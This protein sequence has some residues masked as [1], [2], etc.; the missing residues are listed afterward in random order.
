[1]MFSTVLDNCDPA[2]SNICKNGRGNFLDK[3]F[4]ISSEPFAHLH[5]EEDDRV[6]AAHL[7]PD[8]EGEGDDERPE[9]VALREEVGEGRGGGGADRRLDRLLH[10]A[11]LILDVGVSAQELVMVTYQSVSAS[12]LDLI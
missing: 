11:E 6:D 12:K 3:S 5:A 8:H 1:M 9:E 2:D 10:L 7:L 4:R